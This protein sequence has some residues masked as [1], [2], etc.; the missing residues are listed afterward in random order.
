MFNNYQYEYPETDRLVIIGDIHGDLK[1]FKNI[2]ID[3]KIINNNLEWIAEP[4]NTIVVQLGDQIDSANRIESANNWEILED[5]EMIYFTNTLDNI[6]ISKGGRVISLIG[7]HELMNTQGNF[8]YVSQKSNK[9][10]RINDYHPNG[11]LS[12][13]LSK[14]PVVLKIGKL[15]F[16]HAGL[17]K[18]HLDI[19]RLYYKNISYVNT[20]WKKYMLGEL[21]D[22]N[23][24]NLFE[25]LLTDNNGILW[26]RNLDDT[27]DIFNLFGKAGKYPAQIATSVK[28]GKLI[29]RGKIELGVQKDGYHEYRLDGGKF[30]TRL[31]F[32]VV[33]VK[34]ENTWLVWT[35]YK[36]KM[37]EAKEDKGIW[38]LSKDRYKKLTMLIS[39]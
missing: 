4:S 19:L 8:S 32:R 9:E 31:H 25:K 22:E 14:R 36:Q 23:D 10:T 38:D 39:E 20:L 15:F 35:G 17:K 27:E 24:I 6:A 1:R 21:S 7:N 5:T 11:K 34:E 33:P 12:V 29:D 28:Q 16:C 26:N 18:C 30:E 13:I 3:A 37:L 2:L